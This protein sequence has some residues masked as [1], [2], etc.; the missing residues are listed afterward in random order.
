MRIFLQST[1]LIIT[2]LLLLHFGSNDESL[3]GRDKPKINFYGKLTDSSGKTYSVA[4]ITISG[5]Y[6]QIPLYQKPVDKNH[7]P[8]D[9][10]TRVDFAEIYSIKVP[11][12]ETLLMYKNREYIELEIISADLKRT[13]SNYIIEASKRLVCDQI[14]TAGPIEKDLSFKAVDTLIF[15]GHKSLPTPENKTTIR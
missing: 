4:N 3:A 11:Y 10:I 6:K 7:E 15:E 5:M 14:N 1:G 13:K 9:N 8:T 12:P 2:S